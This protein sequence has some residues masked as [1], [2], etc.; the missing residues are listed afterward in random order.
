MVD[1]LPRSGDITD[2]GFFGTEGGDGAAALDP[3]VIELVDELMAN[4][5]EG[6]GGLVQVLLGLQRAFDRVS[7]RVQELVADRYGMSPAQ[8]AGLVSFFP[9]LSN[10]RRGRMKLDVC[11][12]SACW[13][14]GSSVIPGVLE[15]ETSGLE[16]SDGEPR[17]VSGERCRGVADNPFFTGQNRQ[18]LGRCGVVDPEDI[19]HAVAL[20]AYDGLQL[21]IAGGDPSSV[22]NLVKRNG[23]QERGGSGFPVGLKWAVVAETS[24]DQKFVVGNGEGGDRGPTAGRTLLEGD[25]HSVIEGMA[26]AGFAV[27]ARV[28]RLFLRSEHELAVARAERAVAQA[29]KRG[30]VGRDVLGSGF[31]FSVEICEDAGASM[32]GEETALINVLQGRRG[33][34]RP[35]P[36]FPSVSGLWGQPTLISNL[37]TLANIPAI[38][39]NA[40]S[41]DDGDAGRTRVVGVSG[42]VRRPGLAEIPL[43]ATVSDVVGGIAGGCSKGEIRAVH[44]GGL[45]GVTLRADQLETVIDFATIREFGG[46]LSSGG[47][48]VLGGDDCPVAL[49]KYFVAVC[50]EESCGTCPPCRIGTQVVLGL[51]DRIENGEADAADLDR[52]ERMARHIRRTSLCE[53]GRSAARSVL[54]S[55]ASFREVYEAH[56]S[57]VGCPH[58]E[59]PAE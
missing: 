14:S 2:S 25:P 5:P 12:G 17:I 15:E 47:L 30:F 8:V 3:A 4:A 36:P 50:A 57:A 56:L 49:M 33:V 43:G 52:L 11:A 29:H 40:E 1:D 38:V 37:E 41:G 16:G 48:L 28:G 20:G 22:I 54:A 44:V 24:G 23:L 46:L 6:R 45:G 55:L 18:I 42:R 31:D 13:L 59:N 34:A 7:W 58:R 35:R 21:V 27:G 53:H 9:K 32:S 39:R 51:L 26:I 19:D 10:E